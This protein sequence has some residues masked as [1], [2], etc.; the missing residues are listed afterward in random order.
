MI[1]EYISERRS[2]VIDTSSGR[3]YYRDDYKY[4]ATQHDTDI[5][6]RNTDKIVMKH[7]QH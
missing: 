6:V 2:S 1:D 4:S 5:K 7:V 3:D